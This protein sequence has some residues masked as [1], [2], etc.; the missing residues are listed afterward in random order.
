MEGAA[1]AATEF[2]AVRSRAKHLSHRLSTQGKTPVAA[3]KGDKARVV[4]AAA[5]A[6]GA[7]EDVDA[8]VVVGLE[9]RPATTIVLLPT[10][11]PSNSCS[12]KLYLRGH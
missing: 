2:D 4:G 9:G 3:V 5:D 11:P 12:S 8:A 10:Q 7:V 1:G 6:V